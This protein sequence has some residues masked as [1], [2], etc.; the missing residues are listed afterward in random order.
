V[1]N[2]RA[3]LFSSD[4]EKNAYL[5][6]DSKKTGCTWAHLERLAHNREGWR[7]LVGGQ[8]SGEEDIRKKNLFSFETVAILYLSSVSP[9]TT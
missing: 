4:F 1:N 8:C 3:R 7:K 2:K 9:S 6:K 5:E